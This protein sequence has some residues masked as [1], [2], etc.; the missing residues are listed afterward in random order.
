MTM[1]L[2][3]TTFHDDRKLEWMNVASSDV[4]APHFLLLDDTIGAFSE[5]ITAKR[6]IAATYW[7]RTSAK[8]ICEA[9]YVM[10]TIRLRNGLP[11]ALPFLASL[12][13]T[14]GM[15]RAEQWGIRS[16]FKADLRVGWHIQL[17]VALP[18]DLFCP[19]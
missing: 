18:V 5:C 9:A 15:F 19:S 7:R 16:L 3:S 10:A 8:R 2:W 12:F 1:N 13:G 4:F 6:S 17:G 11:D 14:V